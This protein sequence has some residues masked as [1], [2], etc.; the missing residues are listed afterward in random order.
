MVRAQP[1]H[2]L[3][4]Q[5][6]ERGHRHQGPHLPPNLGGQ[7]SSATFTIAASSAAAAFTAAATFATVTSSEREKRKH[8]EKKEQ[9]IL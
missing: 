1:P 7:T 3:L 6:Q 4:S 5:A 8:I 9:Q 2:P